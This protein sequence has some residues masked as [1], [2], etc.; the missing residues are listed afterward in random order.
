MWI[1]KNILLSTG[2]VGRV[3]L[4]LTLQEL[5]L[6]TC[7]KFFKERKSQLSPYDK[8]KFLSICGGIPRYLEEWQT[9]SSID[10]NINEMC[11]YK[12][13]IL[14]NEFDQIFYDSLSSEATVY[15][16][17]VEALL[18]SSKE[19]NRIAEKLKR[20]PGGDLSD[21]LDNLIT[22]GFVR[23]DYT[24]N[25]KTKTVSSLSHY[26]LSDNY[27]RFYLKYIKPSAIT[28]RDRKYKFNSLSSLP[29]WSTIMG[30]QFEN[31]VLSNRGFIRKQLNLNLDDVEIDGPFFQRTTT[32]VKGC[33]VDYLIQ[34]KTGTLY[35]CEVKFSRKEI[36]I[37][38]IDEMKRKLSKLKVPKGF[39]C[40]PVLIHVNG[41]SD[42]VLDE[43][44][45]FRVLDLSDALS[46]GE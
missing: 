32:K 37:D 3:S 17:I 42:S 33:Q 31:L 11:F 19:R 16:E 15:R 14:F 46:E 40:L 5:P 26:R 41:V 13:G 8:F 23:R 20:T 9:S 4:Q 6:S 2:F 21:Y 27:I 45:F 44:Y 30:L 22:A 35:V 39:S 36:K 1:K 18:V 7:N 34:T 38:I 24:W 25:I 43:N 10:T 12:S 28:I 29:G